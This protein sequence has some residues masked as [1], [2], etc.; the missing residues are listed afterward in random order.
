MIG[1]RGFCGERMNCLAE[2]T[3]ASGDENIGHDFERYGSDRWTAGDLWAIAH[4]SSRRP[5]AAVPR[6]P[7]VGKWR[8]DTE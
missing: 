2:E 7:R 3:M 1:I 5:D 6:D 8:I 4:L